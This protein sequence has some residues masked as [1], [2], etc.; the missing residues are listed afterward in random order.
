MVLKMQRLTLLFK[1]PC[2]DDSFHI[3]GRKWAVVHKVGGVGWIWLQINSF[4]FPM[5][6]NVHSRISGCRPAQVTKLFNAQCVEILYGATEKCGVR[7]LHCCKDGAFQIWA[8]LYQLSERGGNFQTLHA[9]RH[10]TC[11]LNFYKLRN[12]VWWDQAR[13]HCLRIH[14]LRRSMPRPGTWEPSGIFWV[15]PRNASGVTETVTAKHWILLK[16]VTK[17]FTWNFLVLLKCLL[18]SLCLWK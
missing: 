13:S 11:C 12:K 17:M 2:I 18:S 3:L 1:S 7:K 6:A 10:E 15:C 16:V 8:V 4:F 9:W 14:S 5:E